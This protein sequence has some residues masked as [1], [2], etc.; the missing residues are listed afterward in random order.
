MK[1]LLLAVLVLAAL[2]PACGDDDDDDVAAPT[3]TSE[4][5]TTTSTSLRPTTTVALGV[6]LVDP[7]ATASAW[8]AKIASGDDDG[9][10]ALTAPR[11]LEAIGGHDG[12]TSSDTALA[13]GWAAWDAA[14]DLEVK[15]IELD[16]ETAVVILHGQVAQEGPPRESWAA[17]PV[18]ATDDGDRVEPFLDLGHVEAHPSANST[19]PKD[20]RFSAYVLGGRDVDFIVD[21]GQA[22][23]P[24][25][26]GADGDQQLA[27]LDAADLQPGLHVL[28]V[29]LRRAEEIM[30]RTF[31]YTVGS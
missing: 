7:A 12:F 18:V 24:A 15:A 27:E 14:E 4:A 17:L 13:E 10:I 11:S 8:I 16:D 28:T 23:T 19:I 9:A 6:A 20:S 2:F 3:T 26:Q 30:A 5:T 31:E 25:L 21:A 1:K 29:V 22:V